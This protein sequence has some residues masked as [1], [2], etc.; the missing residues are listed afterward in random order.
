MNRIKFWRTGEGSWA[1]GETSSRN[2]PVATIQP[3]EW[4]RP[5]WLRPFTDSSCIG[6]PR[7]GGEI[8]TGWQASLQFSDQPKLQ[9][10]LGPKWLRDLREVFVESVFKLL[11]EVKELKASENEGLAPSNPPS[12]PSRKLRLS[13]DNRWDRSDDA[14]LTASGSRSGGNEKVHISRSFR[15]SPAS[16]TSALTRAAAA[17]STTTVCM[18]IRQPLLQ[19]KVSGKWL[20]RLIL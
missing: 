5:G 4:P 11:S 13:L 6:E 17:T 16:L 15:I 10:L 12:T 14:L 18:Q 7:G 8:G 2:S 9:E 1:R 19:R 3:P 20:A